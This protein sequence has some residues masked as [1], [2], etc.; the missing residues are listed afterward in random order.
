[1]R[2]GV[3]CPRCY[4][5]NM[6]IIDLAL[7]STQSIELILSRIRM[8]SIIM[9]NDIS[10]VYIT[11]LCVFSYV[12]KSNLTYHLIFSFLNH[13]AINFSTISTLIS[14]FFFLYLNLSILK[15]IHIMTLKPNNLQQSIFNMHK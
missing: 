9:S 13:M 6:T 1:M 2:I 11:I 15:H 5:L 8:S 7:S 3:Y 12:C 10:T 14:I 4:I